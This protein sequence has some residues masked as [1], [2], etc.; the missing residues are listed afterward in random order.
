MVRI[1]HKPTEQSRLLVRRLA[2]LGVVVNDIARLT[3]ISDVSVRKYYRNDIARG[4]AEANLQVARA[5]FRAATRDT[6]PSIIA[7]MFWLKN[8]GGWKEVAAAP[9]AG[10]GTNTLRIEFVDPRTA[11]GMNEP[12]M[13]TIDAVP[14]PERAT[15]DADTFD[16]AFGPPAGHGDS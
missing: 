11:P 12:A 5:M 3:E 16:V 13:V 1:A 15:A 4:R 14:E 6:N 8:R 10:D 9:A 7:G 2:G